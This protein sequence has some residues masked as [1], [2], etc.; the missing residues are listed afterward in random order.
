M[1]ASL[2]T[3]AVPNPARFAEMTKYAKIIGLLLAKM[4]AKKNSNY[5]SL[6]L[7]FLVRI[8]KIMF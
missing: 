1:K 8:M 2:I 4:E 7:F 3:K 6:N 5:L